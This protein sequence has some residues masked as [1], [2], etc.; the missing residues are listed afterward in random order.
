MAN[1]INNTFDMME[2]EL[3]KYSVLKIF[4]GSINKNSFVSMK[5]TMEKSINENQ[6]L[7]RTSSARRHFF[8]FFFLKVKTY[9]TI[10]NSDIEDNECN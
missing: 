10:Y 6:L 9:I 3:K 7:L 5:T 2:Y 1:H 4:Y 8:Q